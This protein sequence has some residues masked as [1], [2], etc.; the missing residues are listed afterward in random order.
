VRLGLGAARWNGPR[1][2][3]RGRAEWP[4]E[5]EEEGEEGERADVRALAG[6]GRKGERALGLG[7]SWASA[8]AG[9]REEKEREERKPEGEKGSGLAW[10]IGKEEG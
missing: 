2:Q 1:V 6:R 3:R 4:V 9:P 8:R 7:R 10:P 5:R